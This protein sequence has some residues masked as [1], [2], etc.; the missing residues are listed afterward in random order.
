M[1]RTKI[2]I[3]A[4]SLMIVSPL[5]VQSG[6]SSFIMD[7]IKDAI[8]DVILD[9]IVSSVKDSAKG[10]ISAES[11]NKVISEAAQK[12]RQRGVTTAIRNNNVSADNVDALAGQVSSDEQRLLSDAT[13][14]VFSIKDYSVDFAD[15]AKG[16]AGISS[17]NFINAQ[18][19][20]DAL[21]V[22]SKT[23]A[24]YSQQE[25]LK[26]LMGDSIAL[27][28]NQILT[29]A[30]LDKFVDA[31]K[32]DANFRNAIR[33][34]PFLI[35]R[36]KQTYGTNLCN[37]VAFL[38][39]L[40]DGANKYINMNV[41]LPGSVKMFSTDDLSFSQAG[42]V[43]SVKNNGMDVATISGENIRI[44]NP[45]FLN[46][47]LLPFK[48]YIFND[49]TYATDGLGRVVDVVTSVRANKIKENDKNVVKT[50]INAKQRA[51]GVTNFKINNTYIVPL[52]Y[53]GLCAGINILPLTDVQVKQQKDFFKSQKKLNKGKPFAARAK[54]SYNGASEL[55]TSISYSSYN[56]ECFGNVA[57][58]TIC[59]EIRE[60]SG[61]GGVYGYNTSNKNTVDHISTKDVIQTHSNAVGNRAGGSVASSGK[62]NL[63]GKYKLKGKIN[64]KYPVTMNLTFNN[65]SISGTYYYDKYKRVMTIDGNMS[66]DGK[67]R[68]AEYSDGRQSGEYVGEFDGKCFK[69]EFHNLI[70]D[71]YMPFMLLVE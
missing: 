50:F 70:R 64:Y 26:M 54:I 63:D 19:A 20:E 16:N 57:T 61:F 36:Y 2:S 10:D 47:T 23:Y 58:V 37:D 3:I 31:I 66:S 7:Q 65:S 69:G 25:V 41:M 51:S 9:G 33:Q 27:K 18:L 22:K 59:P 15:L 68:L 1:K 28:A 5:Y 53:G 12:A 38:S 11:Q 4:L 46:L 17:S 30:I 62:Y 8:L 67:I 34:R 43:V 40:E 21:N 39:F 6:I 48:N 56:N 24:D 14:D 29:N 44:D 35:S 55:P 52:E 49:V 71:D 13:N 32:H 45:I 42:N 60:I